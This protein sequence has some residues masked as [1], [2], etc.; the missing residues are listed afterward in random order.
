[1]TVFGSETVLRKVAKGIVELGYARAWVHSGYLSTAK[2]E[3]QALC[4]NAA[5]G[6]VFAG[7]DLF[8]DTKRW[9]I[10]PGAWNSFAAALDNNP[11]LTP[12]E[13]GVP[14]VTDG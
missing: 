5:I 10:D 6:Y 1:M 14:P 4:P 9:P 7:D 3:L 12:Q 11:N 13:H 8:V 2:D